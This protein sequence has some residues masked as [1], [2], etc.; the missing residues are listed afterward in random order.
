MRLPVA[1]THE[2]ITL[3]IRDQYTLLQLIDELNSVTD[4]DHRINLIPW[5]QNNPKYDITNVIALHHF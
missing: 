3:P 2:N 4:A 1:W 5:I